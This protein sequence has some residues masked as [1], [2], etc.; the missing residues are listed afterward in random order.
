[1]SFYIPLVVGLTNTWT[2]AQMKCTQLGN[3]YKDVLETPFHSYKAANV[4][5]YY[6]LNSVPLKYVVKP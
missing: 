3:I 1:M 2:W 5:G 6:G 4:R